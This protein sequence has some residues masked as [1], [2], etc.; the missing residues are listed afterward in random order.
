MKQLLDLLVNRA[1]RTAG[2]PASGTVADEDHIVAAGSRDVQC[3]GAAEAALL[4]AAAE[5][6]ARTA[7]AEH[8]GTAEDL[9]P[10]SGG[11]GSGSGHPRS[12]LHFQFTFL[13]Q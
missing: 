5:Q 6:T 11:F 3:G 4:L 10:Q 9:L 12:H 2:T 7:L 8:P 13:N 1:P